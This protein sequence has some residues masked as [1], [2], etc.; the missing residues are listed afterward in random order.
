MPESSKMEHREKH[1]HKHWRPVPSTCATPVASSSKPPMKKTRAE[2]HPL[3]SK[4]DAPRRPLPSEGVATKI[5]PGPMDPPVLPAM[6]P[7]PDLGLT[8]PAL[9][10]EL[11][12]IVQEAVVQVVQGLPRPQMPVSVPVPE[13]AP[14]PPMLL[15]LLDK[16]GLLIGALPGAPRKSPLPMAPSTPIPLSSG[17]EDALRPEPIPGPSGVPALR[18]PVKSPTPVVGF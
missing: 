16:L 12:R 6:P 10:E 7:T 13:L 3:P 9:Q 15:P 5:P 2:E 8:T 18:P 4:P 1:R 14:M 11:H 17:E